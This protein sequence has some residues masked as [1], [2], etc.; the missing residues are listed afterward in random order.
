MH[1]LAHGL[2][3]GCSPSSVL[4]PTLYCAL[5]ELL[6]PPLLP[7][8]LPPQPLLPSLTARFLSRASLFSPSRISTA[9]CR[10]MIAPVEHMRHPTQGC[11]SGGNKCRYLTPTVAARYADRLFRGV[12]SYM[13]GEAPS[14]PEDLFMYGGEGHVDKG[15]FHG[16]INVDPTGNET[17]KIVPDEEVV[18]LSRAALRVDSPGRVCGGAPR[19]VLTRLARRVDTLRGVDS[20][21]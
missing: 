7:P 6:P 17:R 4:S 18:R 1:H 2:L 3:A 21:V 8:V 10:T 20:L 19:R 15:R 12:R 16:S 5:A 9:C 14:L 11:A 13:S